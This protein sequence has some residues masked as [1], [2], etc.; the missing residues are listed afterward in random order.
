MTPTRQ[1]LA[2]L[3][4]VG[5]AACGSN[6]AGNDTAAKDAEAAAR[7]WLAAADS[8]DGAETWNLAAAD[9]QSRITSEQWQ[10]ALAAVREPLGTLKTRSPTSSK[11]V[12]SLPDAP[13]GDYVVMQLQSEFEHK[14]NGWKP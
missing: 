8:G 6:T 7:T 9:F 4:L 1:S 14:A 3:L 12:M 13:D 2:A 5:V 10:K 11:H